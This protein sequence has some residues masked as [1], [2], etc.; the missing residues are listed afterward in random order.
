MDWSFDWNITKYVKTYIDSHFKKIIG[1][2]Y[3]MY[4]E[5]INSYE[6]SFFKKSEP[7]NI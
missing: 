4:Y 3:V 6:K 7:F 2:Q 5:V 1:I